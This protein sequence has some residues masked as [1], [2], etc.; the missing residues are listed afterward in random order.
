MTSN[1]SDRDAGEFATFMR[2]IG[3]VDRTSSASGKQLRQPW[4]KSLAD[5]STLLGVEPEDYDHVLNDL[6]NTTVSP[7]PSPSPG[8]GPGPHPI[9]SCR[10]VSHGTGE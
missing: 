2:T 6:D 8:P 3:I 4:P 10:V 5:G 7:S 9:L 1:L